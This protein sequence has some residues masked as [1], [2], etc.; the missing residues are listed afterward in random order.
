MSITG[1]ADT[2]FGLRCS[3]GSLEFWMENGAGNLTRV[4]DSF[5]CQDGEWHHLAGCREITGS[6]VNIDLYWDGTL[7]G[8]SSG[9]IDTIGQNTSVYIGHYPYSDSILGLGGY[10]DKVRI[11]DSLRYTSDFT[12]ELYHSTDSST[13]AFYD[14][15]SLDGDTFE[16]QSGNGYSGQVYGASVDNICPE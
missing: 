7:L 8:S 6:T 13:V 1:G 9:N 2:Y 15:L 14:F 11:S 5:E 4:L 16:D 12:P 3:Y 10:I